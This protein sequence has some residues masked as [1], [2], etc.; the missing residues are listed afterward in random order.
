ML[1]LLITPTLGGGEVPKGMAGWMEGELSKA[2]SP[3]KSVCLSCLC[4]FPPKPGST[5]KILVHSGN[6]HGRV[7]CKEALLPPHCWLTPG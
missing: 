3:L 5:G 4:I 1:M 7:L 6:V 2:S